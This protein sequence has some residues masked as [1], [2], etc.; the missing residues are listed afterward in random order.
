M[1]PRV[2]EEKHS[3]SFAGTQNILR[4]FRFHSTKFRHD[5]LFPWNRYFLEKLIVAHLVN[6]F[7]D[8]YGTP[9][10]P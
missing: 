6:K 5:V 3:S 7:A 8:F 10:D 9:K 2:T 1:C 4:M